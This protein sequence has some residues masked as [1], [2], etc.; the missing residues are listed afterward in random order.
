MSRKKALLLFVVIVSFTLMTYQSKK[1]RLGPL[2]C[3]GTALHSANRAFS[4]VTGS[5]SRPFRIMFLREAENTALKKQVDRLLLEQNATQEAVI[6]NRRLKELLKLRETQ[7]NYVAAGRVIARGVGHWE[8]TLVI[9]KGL[10]DGVVKDMT[11]MTPKGLAGKIVSV[12]ESF[13]TML[14]ITDINF[15][16]AGRL[17]EK[18]AEGVVSGSGSRL[19]LLKY[20]PYEEE[21]KTGDVVITS[22]LDSLFPPGIPVGYVSKVDTK[23]IGGNFQYIEVT[24]YQE[25]SRLEEVIIVR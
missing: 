18:R 4:S 15:S 17:R 3:L 12:S 11:V 21:V 10:K 1:G 25:A 16:A 9:D 23:G 6:E 7:R 13:S 24:P 20:I 5:L 2:P 19:C 22:G 14:W 8:H